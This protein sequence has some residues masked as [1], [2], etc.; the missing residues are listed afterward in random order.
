[1]VNADDIARLD[2]YPNLSDRDIQIVYRKILRF[3]LSV[4]GEVQNLSPWDVTGDKKFDVSDLIV[5]RRVLSRKMNDV[6]MVQESVSTDFNKVETKVHNYIRMNLFG[7]LNPIVANIDFNNDDKIN[8]DDVIIWRSYVQGD[9][10]NDELTAV[11]SRLL[12]L[13]T[14]ARE[15]AEVKMEQNANFDFNDSGEVD[16]LDIRPLRNFMRKIRVR[17]KRRNQI[18]LTESAIA[19]YLS[20]TQEFIPEFDFNHDGKSDRNDIPFLVD[21]RSYVDPHYSLVYKE[22]MNLGL[23]AI[24]NNRRD[25]LVLDLFDSDHDTEVESEEVDRILLL[26]AR[27]S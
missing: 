2:S 9:L 1:M 26:I 3:L 22:I 8:V 17:Y 24:E 16:I 15:E 7:N 10:P 23:D 18:K 6:L 5:I 19:K 21:F 11:G 20:T 14:A 4:S 25:R 13:F 12:E 27:E